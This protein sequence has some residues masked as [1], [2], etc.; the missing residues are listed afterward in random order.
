MRITTNNGVK[1]Q[2]KALKHEYLI[3]Y[4]DRTLSGLMTVLVEKIFPDAFRK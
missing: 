2:N 3:A 4:R 1:R